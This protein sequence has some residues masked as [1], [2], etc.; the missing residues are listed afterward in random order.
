MLSFNP[1][2]ITNPAKFDTLDLC[3][4]FFFLWRPF[5]TS[6]LAVMNGEGVLLCQ[7]TCWCHTDDTS[8]SV[9]C[10]HS[11]FHSHMYRSLCIILSFPPTHT[12]I[13]TAI[14][15]AKS[16]WEQSFCVAR[17]CHCLVCLLLFSFQRWSECLF[18]FAVHHRIFLC[19]YLANKNEYF[20]VSLLCP[21]KPGSEQ[22]SPFGS[23]LT[24]VCGRVPETLGKC[25]GAA[26]LLIASILYISHHLLF[27]L[28]QNALANLQCVVS[29]WP[30]MDSYVGSPIKF[31]NVNLW[32]SNQLLF[33]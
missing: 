24:C 11:H 25:C 22:A 32:N 2:K 6:V 4:H 27:L 28:C 33:F 9:F 29:V 18:D 20:Q 5:S 12:D 30:S 13:Q 21:P 17:W 3:N 8:V 15:G 16:R 31:W 10:L 19:I 14:S 7:T 1:Y 23:W 26:V